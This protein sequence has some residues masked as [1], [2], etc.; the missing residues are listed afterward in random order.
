MCFQ[1]LVPAPWRI[2]SVSH[3]HAFLDNSSN[4][5]CYEN[6]DRRLSGAVYCTDHGTLLQFGYCMTYEE[7]SGTFLA[8]CPY[9]SFRAFNVTE[10]EYIQLPDHTSQLNNSMCDPLKRKGRVCS[11]CKEGYAIAINSYN[12]KCVECSEEL[13]GVLY[14]LPNAVY[15]HNCIL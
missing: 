3:G 12:Y 4:C 11:D 10:S 1:S 2:C 7:D 6:S 14:Y 9:F 15:T 8:Q 13:H 5:E